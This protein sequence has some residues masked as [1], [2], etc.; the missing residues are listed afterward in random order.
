MNYEQ[1]IS[2]ESKNTFKK[3]GSISKSGGDGRLGGGHSEGKHLPMEG[4]GEGESVAGEGK[5]ESSE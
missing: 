4:E 2:F 3:L 5:G 1:G